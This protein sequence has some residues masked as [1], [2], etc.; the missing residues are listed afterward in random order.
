MSTKI[1]PNK[2]EGVDLECV[3]EAI[4]TKYIAQYRVAV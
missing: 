1:N 2:A 3:D 4:L